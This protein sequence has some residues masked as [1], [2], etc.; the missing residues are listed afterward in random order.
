MIRQC[1]LVNTGIQ[2]HRES[3]KDIGLDP[4]T[5]FPFVTPRPAAL[6]PSASTVA[7]VKAYTHSAEPTDATLTDE[8]QAS[9]IA[10]STFKTEED[11]ELIDAL[12]P[13]FDQL[14]LSRFWW[15]LEILPLRH[16]AQNRDNM[17]WKPH[18]QY[19]FFPK[20]LSSLCHS[21]VSVVVLL[22][23]N[24]GRPRRI[25]GPVRK[26]KEKIFV[27][28]SVKT[29]MDADDLE[30]GKYEPQAKFEQFDFEWVD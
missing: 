21:R 15:I 9:P 18:W 25:P 2:F 10:A 27:H 17:L 20:F 4:A 30:G 5:L 13:I 26:R 1:F 16:R 11:E 19:V 12:S 24:F 14:K 23:A 8:A 7:D 3:F 22:R 6:K 29:R 28:R